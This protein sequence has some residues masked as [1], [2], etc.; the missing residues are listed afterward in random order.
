M[1]SIGAPLAARQASFD[2]GM[3]TMRQ[4]EPILAGLQPLARQSFEAHAAVARDF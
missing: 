2:F 4:T 1:S 3:E